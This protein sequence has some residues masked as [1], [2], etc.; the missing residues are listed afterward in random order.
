MTRGPDLSLGLRVPFAL[1]GPR[2]SGRGRVTGRWGEEG[3]FPE[4]RGRG[5]VNPTDTHVCTRISY[6]HIRGAQ[7]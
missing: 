1:R 2:C 6:P 5:G 7:L 4:A 3:N